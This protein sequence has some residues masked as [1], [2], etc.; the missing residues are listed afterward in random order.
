M[1]RN[2]F[3]TFYRSLSLLTEE[4]RGIQRHFSGMRMPY[5]NAVIGCPDSPSLWV[6]GIEE[7]LAFFAA[8]DRRFVWYVDETAP[9]MFKEMLLGKG[10]TDEGMLRG[11]IGPLAQ[12]IPEPRVDEGYSIERV[13][14][15]EA[16]ERFSGVVSEIFGIAEQDRSRYRSFLWESAQASPPLMAHW[17]VRKENRIVSALTTLMDG[18]LVSFWNGATLPEERK[19]GLSTALRFLALRD[20]IRRGC[21]QGT[22]Y[23]MTGGMS[24]GICS[25]LGFQTKWRFH[26]F[27]SP[28]KAPVQNPVPYADRFSI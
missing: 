13:Q 19:K 21:T 6:A 14:D 16:I 10:F 9:Q 15:L 20:A 3:S 23:L 27:V 25:K 2:S 8:A 4:N 12:P 1:L 18:D 24:F 22:S 11:V 28:P 26:A 7:E 5:Q 17:A